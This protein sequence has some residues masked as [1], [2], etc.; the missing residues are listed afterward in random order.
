MT[1]LASL[2]SNSF[3]PRAHIDA[4]IADAV[5]AGRITSV[6]Q[7]AL[8][9]I[10]TSLGG[11]AR[12][13]GG[14]V[15]DRIDGLIDQQVSNGTLSQDQAGALQNFFAQGTVRDRAAPPADAPPAD[16]AP[17]DAAPVEATG[18]A[19]A[20]RARAASPQRTAMDDERRQLTI[21]VDKMRQSMAPAVTYGSSGIGAAQ[22]GL[23]IDG[24]A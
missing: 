21:L 15:K 1:S 22:A 18:T 6:D 20:L 12:R 7:T 10:D 19:A 13:D 4:R 9:N 24:T 5:D 16:S 11:A 14:S 17:A 23:I 3:A 2:N 8:D